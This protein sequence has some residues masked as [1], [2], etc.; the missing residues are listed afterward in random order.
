MALSRGR[1]TINEKTMALSLLMMMLDVVCDCWMLTSL[2]GTSASTP[3]APSNAALYD[4]YLQP[5]V[6]TKV[7][8]Q[9]SFY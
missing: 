5:A 3:L 1:G 8:R 4:S 7:D 2:C 6:G 9:N